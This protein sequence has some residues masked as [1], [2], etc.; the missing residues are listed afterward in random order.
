MDKQGG[1]KSNQ[2]GQER[3]I[4]GKPRMSA[5]NEGRKRRTGDTDMEVEVGARIKMKFRNRIWYPIGAISKIIKGKGGEVV[6]VGI[7]FDDGEKEVRDWPAKNI[8]VDNDNNNEEKTEKKRSKIEAD[9]GSPRMFAC[10]EKGC[11]FE[12]KWKK[13][14]K[15]HKANVH[16]IDVTYYLCNVDGCIYKAKTAGDLRRHKANVHDIDVTYYLCNADGCEYKAKQ[17]STLI[18]HQKGIHGIS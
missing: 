14:V 1:E 9:A 18:R 12:S 7:R 3:T 6:K 4:L 13:A 2:P 8:A 5:T 10:G 16:D 11:E 17:S 15:T